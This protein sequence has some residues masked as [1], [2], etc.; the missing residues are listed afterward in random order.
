VSLI[1]KKISPKTFGPHCV[2][3][4]NLSTFFRNWKPQLSALVMEKGFSEMVNFLQTPQCPDMF[5]H[6]D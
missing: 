5:T 3:G 6:V 4:R 1:F 2:V